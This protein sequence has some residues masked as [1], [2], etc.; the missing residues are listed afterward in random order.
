MFHV[1]LAYPRSPLDD[2]TFR[3]GPFE[4][5][6]SGFGKNSES[7]PRSWDLEEF[8]ASLWASIGTQKNS[9]L[10]PSIWALGLENISS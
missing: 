5:M 6:S 8:R 4:K 3:K 1:V 9:E 7:L 10:S 2:V